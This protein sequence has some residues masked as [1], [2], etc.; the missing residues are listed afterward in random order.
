MNFTEEEKTVD[1]GK[2]VYEDMLS[3]ESVRTE[4][5]LEGYGIRILKTSL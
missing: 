1:L 5:K 4:I 2:E 3:G